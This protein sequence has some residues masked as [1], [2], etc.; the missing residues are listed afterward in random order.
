MMVA[1]FG[2]SGRIW[3]ATARH[4]TL[5]ASAVSWAKAMDDP[6]QTAPGELAQELRPDRFGLGG[7]DLHA[8]HLAPAVT[9]DAHGD[10]EG[11]GLPRAADRGARPR[12]CG[13]R[14]APSDR[15]R[16]SKRVANRTWGS[17]NPPA[18][19]YRY[20]PDRKGEHGQAL[21]AP[22]SGF[23]HGLRRA[24]RPIPAL[25]VRPRPGP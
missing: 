9:V 25:L 18:A 7:A 4:C 21:L 17:P 20:S 15:S 23:L 5:A 2:T 13:R 6:A 10:D 3:S 1:S 24:Q 22:A 19:F 11:Q 12:R 14:G 16:L 8:Q